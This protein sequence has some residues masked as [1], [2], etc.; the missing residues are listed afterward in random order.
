M[1][2]QVLIHL[3]D[4]VFHRFLWRTNES[5]KPKVYHWKRLNF[6][7]KPAP[8]IAAGA[9]ITL[10]K[11]AQ[12]QY[13]E[14]AKE[15]RTHVYVND[16]GGSRENE[17]KSKQITSEI[18]TILS[19]GQFQIK[20]WHSNN[21][22]IGQTDE[23]H[24]DFLGHKWNKTRDTNTFKKTEIIAEKPVTKR[25]CLPYLAQLW[26]PT[27]LETPTAIEMRIDLLELWSAGYSWDE[28]LPDET[29]IKWKKSVQVFNQLLT[30]QFKRKPK[31]DNA[32]GL[33][34]IHGFYDAGKKAYGSS[35]FLRWKLDD[36]SHTCV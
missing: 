13:P 28:F 29:Q 26:D 30:Y 14:A 21:K 36:G 23:E 9:I 33:P 10:A 18:D 24:V 19:K 2:N 27:G 3:D 5:L 35:M 4:Q 32:V 20:Q 22:K 7:D 12:D 1:F 34:E 16:I 8:N 25:N 11:A 31:A 15:S 6:G 17:D